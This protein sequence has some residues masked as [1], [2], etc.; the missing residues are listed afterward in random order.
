[1]RTDE[2]AQIALLVQQIRGRLRAI[3]SNMS[4]ADFDAMTQ[5]M[6]EVEYHGQA[7]AVAAWMSDSA[8]LSALG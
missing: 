6:A 2:R 3:C 5:R 1:M 7:R 8:R 4:P